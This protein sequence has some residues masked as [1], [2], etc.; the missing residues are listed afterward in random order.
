MHNLLI[1]VRCLLLVCW[2][3]ACC[4]ENTNDVKLESISHEFRETDIITTFKVSGSLPPA[5]K[6]QA[7]MG[8][9]TAGV[10]AALIKTPVSFAAD[11]RTARVTNSINNMPDAHSVDFAL[12]V[13]DGNGN[14]LV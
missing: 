2:G 1:P 5:A 8:I 7:L 14:L 6:A 10:S 12:L 13:N 3:S 11:N 4:A 9:H